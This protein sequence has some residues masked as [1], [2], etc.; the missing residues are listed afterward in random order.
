M[1]KLFVLV[2]IL[3]GLSAVLSVRQQTARQAYLR[4]LAEDIVSSM[5]LNVDPCADFYNYSCGNWIRNNPLPADKAAFF[6]AITS[7][8][9]HNLNT[10][11]AIVEDPSTGK[12]N[13]VYQACMNT[14]ITN[15]LNWQPIK[16]YL[17]IVAQV[18]DFTTFFSM[19]GALQSYGFSLIFSFGVDLDA[20]NPSINIAQFGQGAFALPS[21][22]L[23]LDNSTETQKQRQLYL[24]HIAVMFQFVGLPKDQAIADANHV[25][26][27]ETLLAQA[28][29]PDDQLIDPF[30]TYNKL[31][32]TGLQTISPN[33]PWDSYLE[34]LG[35]PDLQQVNVISPAFFQNLSTL[36]ANTEL[37]SE[38]LRAYLAWSVIHQSANLLSDEFVNATFAFF[39]V[40]LEGQAEMSPRWET[41]ISAVDSTVG[42]MLGALYAKVSFSG[43]SLAD[44]KTMLD[45]IEGAMQRDIQELNWMDPTTR[46]RALTKLSEVTNQVGYPQ[47]PSNYTHLP[48]S[49]TTYAENT[50]NAQSYQ[51]IS[52][53]K[54]IGQPANKQKWGMT[55]D[56]VNAYYDPTRNQMVFPAGILQNPYFN[57]SHPA[58]LNYGGAGVIMGHELT[59]GFDNQGRDYNGKG[60][61]ENWWEPATNKQFNDKAQCIIDQYS[62]FEVLPGLYLNGKLTQGEN[63]ADCGGVKNSYNAFLKN[64]GPASNDTSVVPFLTNSQLFFVGYAQGWCAVA[65]PAY[66]RVQVATDPHSTARYRVLGPLIN[67]EQF[68]EQFKC[69]VGSFMNPKV[70]CPVW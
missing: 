33:L 61:L 15:Q 16:P 51:F 12:V 21:R 65:S 1:S 5:D 6:K 18:T 11:K 39:G 43:S 46:A 2:L 36:V 47:N 27:F 9:D 44:A 20:K 4:G 48:L 52:Q 58:A 13:T 50:F 17:D 60:V 42:E 57:A 53:V 19:A 54:S 23:Y 64:V 31:D 30:K 28:G 26:E 56:T 62:K 69:P 49:T 55:A 3:V 32:I 66:L 34:G 59:H 68:A 40:I 14:E 22:D 8:E 25:L 70:R 63:I 7:I 41:C 10:L 45:S 67:L 29:L 24:D 35:F 37:P 38:Q